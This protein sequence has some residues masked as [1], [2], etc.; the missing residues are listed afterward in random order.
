MK[1]IFHNRKGQLAV[2]GVLFGLLIFVILWAMFF[3][4]Q[5]TYW[6]NGMIEQNN[7]TGI[8][9]FFMS[10]MN[11]WVLIGAILGTLAAMYFGGE[12]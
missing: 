12:Q 11:L 6:S 5:I 8:E 3:S 10:Y 2:M 1:D 7:L 4:E 9:A